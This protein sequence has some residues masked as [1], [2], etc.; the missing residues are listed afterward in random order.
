M[1]VF[2]TLTRPIRSQ[3]E[4][5]S[6]TVPALSIFSPVGQSSA[7]GRFAFH[8]EVPLVWAHLLLCGIE[9]GCVIALAIEKGT[10]PA[11]KVPVNEFIRDIE[12]RALQVSRHAKSGGPGAIS[13]L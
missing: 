10:D 9:H 1:T 13:F 12:H 7:F 4:P 3:N 5:P 8:P 6:R 2:H 11:G